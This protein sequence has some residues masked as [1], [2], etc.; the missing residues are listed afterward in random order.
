M[1]MLAELEALIVTPVS[2]LM[3]VLFFFSICTF[4]GV[5]L[6]EIFWSKHNYPDCLKS[7]TAIVFGLKNWINKTYPRA[8]NFIKMLKSKI[9]RIAQLST[10]NQITHDQINKW[11]PAMTHNN[12]YGLSLHGPNKNRFNTLITND[13]ISIYSFGYIHSDMQWCFCPS[14]SSNPLTQSQ[15]QQSLTRRQELSGCTVADKTRIDNGTFCC[16]RS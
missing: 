4:Q 15:D 3:T 5:Y 14:S 6:S 10:S 9:K 13:L 8:K 12:K 16:H 7:G 11:D 2:P 1:W